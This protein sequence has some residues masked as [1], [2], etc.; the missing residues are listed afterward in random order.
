VG[1]YRPELL[2]SDDYEVWLR[3][4]MDGTRSPNSTA[5]TAAAAEGFFDHE[6]GQIAGSDAMRR[7]AHRGIA[8]RAYWSAVSHFLQRNPQGF[9]LL[10]L[11]FTLS[12]RTALLPR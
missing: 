5:F 4:A 9:N 6:G 7:L 2:H 1:H 11:A 3:L 12:P 8:H 10:K